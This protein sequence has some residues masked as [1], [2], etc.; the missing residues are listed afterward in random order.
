MTKNILLI[1]GSLNQPRQMRQI[2]RQLAKHHCVFAPFYA[3]G[4]HRDGDVPLFETLLDIS[5]G[6]GNLI[7]KVDSIDDRFDLPGLHQ[8]FKKSQ[9]FWSAV[10]MIT[11]LP[12]LSET[13]PPQTLWVS[14]A[15]IN[16]YS[17]FS[18]LSR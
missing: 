18:F 8:L 4:S 6:F 17:L 16:K 14:S 9:V 15:L 10:P 5:M 3:D 1:S 13:Q 2:A 7:Q 12:L 11:F